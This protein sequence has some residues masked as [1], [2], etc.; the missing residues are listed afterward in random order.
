MESDDVERLA[1]TQKGMASDQRDPWDSSGHMS[2]GDFVLVKFGA[3]MGKEGFVKSVTDS[4][5]I[6]VGETKKDP[7]QPPFIVQ[8][9]L[10]DAE[11]QLVGDFF[12]HDLTPQ[13]HFNQATF[14]IAAIDTFC[15]DRVQL[16]DVI[17]V[18]SGPAR[19]KTGH[20]MEIR[21]CGY[22]SIKEIA[23]GFTSEPF[24]PVKTEG[25][26]NQISRFLFLL[27]LNPNLFRRRGC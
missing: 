23:G 10:I 12:D 24:L 17:R 21:P 27:A 16:Y 20:V 7:S 26:S 25:V 5:N 2:P 18:V 4:H 15:Y 9:P 8:W 19:G 22:L 6:L 3:L 14:T 11:V 1:F 13:A